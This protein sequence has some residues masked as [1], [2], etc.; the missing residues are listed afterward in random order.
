MTDDPINRMTEMVQRFNQDLLGIPIPDKPTMLNLERSKFRLNHLQEE[1]KET[2]DAMLIDDLPEA[3]DGLIDLVYVALGTLVEMGVTAGAAF[4]EVHAANM[5]KERGALSRRPDSLGYDATKPEGWS[6]PNLTPY[7][8]LT[9]EDIGLLV[10]ELADLE[11]A[12]AYMGDDDP[13]VVSPRKKILVLGHGQHGKDTTSRMLAERGFA[14]TSSSL[15][16]AERVIWPLIVDLELAS[17]FV[18]SLP[19]VVGTQIGFELQA[20]NREYTDSEECFDDRANHR[21]LWY[22]AIKAFNDPNPT[23]LGRAIFEEHDVYCG[24]RNVEELEALRKESVFDVAVWIDRSNYVR[25]ESVLSCTVNAH[26]ADYTIDNNGTID[27]L[28][29]N[30]G[31]FLEKIR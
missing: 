20:M 25:P 6:P 10:D 5:R 12:G 8:T 26:M 29:R 3:V 2:K 17:L 14:F 24:L 9:R 13:I 15:F 30:V 27:D 7:L 28:R 16:C 1:L 19:Y 23:K 21:T 4:E 11:R 31:R 18:A 22:E